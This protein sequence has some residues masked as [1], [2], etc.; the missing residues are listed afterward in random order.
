MT[1]AQGKDLINRATMRNADGTIGGYITTPD[2][3]GKAVAGYIKEMNMVWAQGFMELVLEER[4]EQQPT[5]ISKIGTDIFIQ[6]S[7]F[8]PVPVA[9][10]NGGW[11]EVLNGYFIAYS[12]GSRQLITPVPYRSVSVDGVLYVDLVEFLDAVGVVYS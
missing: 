8:P 7:G 11:Y 12:A 4:Y 2:K 1:R 9:D 10:A 3:S 5:T 6:Q